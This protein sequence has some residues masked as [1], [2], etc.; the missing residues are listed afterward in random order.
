[1]V[2]FPDLIETCQAWNW[3]HG[4][5]LWPL[6]ATRLPHLLQVVLMSDHLGGHQPVC[7]CCEHDSTA[8]KSLQ[9]SYSRKLGL[10][11]AGNLCQ[12]IRMLFLVQPWSAWQ[13]KENIYQQIGHQ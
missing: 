3:T 1:M 2:P 9:W 6:Q 5:R 10:L 8:S 12:T 4:P 11:P 13:A 7:L